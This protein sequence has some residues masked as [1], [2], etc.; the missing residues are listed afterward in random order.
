MTTYTR[1]AAAAIVAV[2]AI[3]GAIYLL[4]PRGGIGPGGPTPPATPTPAPTQSDGQ[5]GTITL[6]DDACAWEG[7]PSPITATGGRVLV[8]FS[9]RNET[10]TFGNFGIYRLNPDRTWAEAEAWMIAENAALDGGP[11]HPPQDFATDVANVDA[12]ERR[13]YPASI[14]L[15]PGTFGIV[16]SSNEPPPGE[17]FAVHLVGP[18]EI[19]APTQ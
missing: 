5:I 1:L 14:T 4:N 18:L 8:R 3:G 17:V 19:V 10:D 2:I 12:P 11:S 7:N 13:E 15:G 6:T 9:V 16:C